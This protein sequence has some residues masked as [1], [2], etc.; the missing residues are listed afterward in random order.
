MRPALSPALYSLVSLSFLFAVSAFPQKGWG[1]K[2]AAQAPPGLPR[3]LLIGDSI[4]N[5]YRGGVARR[6]EGKAAV[7]AWVTPRH[8]ASAGLL[9]ELNRVLARGPYQVIHFNIGL[10]GWPKGRIPKGQYD[11]LVRR[12]FL[13]LRERAPGAVL[14][15]A[16]T[17]PIT[18]QGKPTLLDPELNPII[19]KRNA[20]AAR[21]AAEYGIALDDLYGLAAR[22]LDLG[23]GDRFH[24]KREGFELLAWQVS[25]SVLAALEARRQR[26]RTR[27]LRLFVAPWGKPGAAGTWADPL[28]SPEDAR[29]VLRALK[30]KK[31]LPPGGVRIFL[32]GGLYR[33]ARPL[34]L[35]P[36]D[37]GRRGKPVVYAA[38][39]GETPVLTGGRR[40][41]GWK[42]LKEKLPALSP[43]AEGKIW[44]ASIPKGW[45][46]HYLFVDGK[47][48]VRSRSCNDDF[49]RHWPRKF[50]FGPPDPKGQLVTFPDKS[51]LA[52]VPSNGDTEMVLV[53]AQYGKMANGVLKSVDPEKGTARWNDTMQNIVPSR[54]IHER[55]YRLENALCF[56]DEPGE[57]AVDSAEGR[58]YYWPPE[59]EMEGAVAEAPL[60]YELI[61]LEGKEGKGPKV[62]FVEIRGLTLSRTDRLPEDQW[63]HSWLRRQW[64][65]PDGAL[66]ISNAED[67][68][69]EGCRILD[70]GGYGIVLHHHARRCRI[71][72]N[73]V[74][75]TGAGGIFLEG[76]GP[77]FTDA[78]NHNIVAFNWFHDHGLGN[79]WHS[80]GIQ[81]YQS[82]Y[83][84]VEYNLIQRSAYNGISTTGA[85]PD[86]LSRIEYV[87]P[88]HARG[89]WDPWTVYEPKTED[90]P[91]DL[92]EKIRKREF[93]FDRE[94]VKPLLHSNAN[95]IQH[96]VIVEPHS[97]L[98]EGGAIYAW[99]C[100]R[101][102]VWR[103][104]LIY[105]SRGMPASSV[106]A[107]DD[108]VEFTTVEDNV[109]RVDGVILDGVGA[110]PAERGDILRNNFR[111]CFDPRFAARRKRGLG[112]AWINITG[113]APLDRLY[114]SIWSAVLSRGGWPSS[115]RVGIPGLEDEH[116]TVKPPQ[117]PVKK[118]KDMHDVIDK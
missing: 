68:V 50:T 42:P 90:W 61:R 81:I 15:W 66:Y 117:A 71:L 35:T 6:L 118:T 31:G 107:L 69:V 38:W 13:F 74:G 73:E 48:A 100:G 106:I 99:C 1:F 46:F 37:S 70:P 19:V 27:P 17:T 95:L 33:L 60:L 64:E 82:G 4:C 57:W 49:W 34:A 116:S 30:K 24:Y 58:V 83:N 26:R 80:P 20:L 45:R 14:V 113:R 63:P 54:N 25:R 55:G 114:R 40:I 22:H 85:D 88:G 11:N 108:L 39:P 2:P 93:M 78:N 72:G 65:I 87:E 109:F 75:R 59:G 52:H 76:Y 44:Y 18:V 28:P 103:A 96:N 53:L 77:G 102:N 112:K 43:K 32:R 115:P 92:L 101:W 16:S 105:K 98:N 3:V 41:T 104:N 51:L 12:Y 36:E 10:H 94:T 56:L 89:Q 7:D 110:R 67:C 8:L 23:R 79:Y 47:R 21:A 29:N 84:L 97:T 5:G 62:R 86:R 9:K 91:R 111:A